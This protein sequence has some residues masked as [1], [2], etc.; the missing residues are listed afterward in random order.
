MYLLG[1]ASPWSLRMPCKPI[2]Y[3]QVNCF[4]DL[5]GSAGLNRTAAFVIL[6]K[7]SMTTALI[8][9]QDIDR[10]DIPVYPFI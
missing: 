3:R 1:L 6:K 4:I 7:L 10:L 2:A 9:A 8:H 5:G